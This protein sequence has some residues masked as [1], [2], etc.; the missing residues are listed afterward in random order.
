MSFK[1]QSLARDQICKCNFYCHEQR[2]P[3]CRV[4]SN[5]KNILHNRKQESFCSVKAT[6]IGG[7]RQLNTDCLLL[8]SRKGY[9][10]CSTRIILSIN[11]RKSQ[12]LI[13]QSFWEIL[14][15][16]NIVALLGGTMCWGETKLRSESEVGE[17]IMNER[18][19][20]DII[21]VE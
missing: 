10:W 14:S 8:C 13:A 18:H 7:E 16:K 9:F 1:E 5:E 20:Q 4:I 12:C 19:F 3:L 15:C 17:K 11:L 2:R 21:D 6:W